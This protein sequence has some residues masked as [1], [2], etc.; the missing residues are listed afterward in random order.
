MKQLVLSVVQSVEKRLSSRDL[1]KHSTLVFWNNID[2]LKLTGP[3]LHAPPM[4]SLLMRASSHVWAAARSAV[5]ES[6]YEG[7]GERRGLAKLVGSG[8]RVR[9]DT[10]SS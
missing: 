1:M 6:E 4:L 3:L 7:E 10:A 2:V 8:T 9:C 5:D